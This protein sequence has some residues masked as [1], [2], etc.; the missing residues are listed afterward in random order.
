MKNLVTLLFICAVLGYAVGCIN[1]SF[2]LAKLKGYDI[3]EHGS[4]N[5]GAS[6]L[7]ITMGKGIGLTVALIDIMKAYLVTVFSGHL[8]S[9]DMVLAQFVCATFVI[10]G[11]IFPFYMGFK[12]G[13]GFA[14]LGGS[15]LAIDI[16]LFV[17]LLIIVAVI[18]FVTDY[19]CFGPIFASVAFPISYGAIYRTCIPSVFLLATVAITYRH[20]ENLRR[21]VQG[22]ELRFSFLWNRKKEAERLGIEDDGKNYPFGHD[23]RA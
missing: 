11:N 15:V 17:I 2:I 22:K 1:L 20:F 14:S 9:A 8:F 13:K 10:L 21:I 19:I 18:V 3:R 23:N 5:A 6:N 12:G 7:M 16:K 4:G